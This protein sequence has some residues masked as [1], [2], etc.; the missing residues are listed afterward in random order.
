MS[1]PKNIEAVVKINVQVPAHPTQEKID[2]VSGNLY[3]AAAALCGGMAKELRKREINPADG[4]MR[5]ILRFTR[6]ED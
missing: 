1:D 5:L 3:A 6:K 2:E 4:E